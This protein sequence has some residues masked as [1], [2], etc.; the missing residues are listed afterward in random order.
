[1][2]GIT[3]GCAF[4]RRAPAGF[5]MMIIP[6]AFSARG[7]GHLIAKT[8]ACFSKAGVKRPVLPGDLLR[9]CSKDTS[10]ELI[11]NSSWGDVAKMPRRVTWRCGFG[12]DGDWKG[13][14][15]AANPPRDEATRDQKGRDGV[16]VCWHSSG[17]WR[18]RGCVST[19]TCDGRDCSLHQLVTVCARQ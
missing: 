10:S 12:H 18:G 1:M 5:N 11:R 3:Q 2:T 13:G 4:E 6:G 8:G 19:Y 17:V 14:Q 16:C 9:G 15:I 7:L